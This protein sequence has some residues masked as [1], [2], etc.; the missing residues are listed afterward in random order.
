[1]STFQEGHQV[2]LKYL[3]TLGQHL[4]QL[5]SGLS[6]NHSGL[7]QSL[8]KVAETQHNHFKVKEDIQRYFFLGL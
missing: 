5:E 1:L 6:T 8:E 7:Q 2:H 3:E 4:K